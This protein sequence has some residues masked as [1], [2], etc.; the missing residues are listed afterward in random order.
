[1][2]ENPKSARTTSVTIQQGGALKAHT[3]QTI[4]KVRKIL[5]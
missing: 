1:M 5:T 4:S 2:K 3:Q